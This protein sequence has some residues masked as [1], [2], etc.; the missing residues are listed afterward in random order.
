V[1]YPHEDSW[2]EVARQR[3]E[4]GLRSFELHV[5]YQDDFAVTADLAASVE[6]AG[7]KVG[8]HFERQQSTIWAINGTFP[9]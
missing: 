2:Q 8:G 6:K 9:R 5:T 7:L 1:W 4:H 3:L